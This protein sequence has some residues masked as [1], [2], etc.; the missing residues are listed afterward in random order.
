MNEIYQLKSHMK[1]LKGKEDV[2]IGVDPLDLLSKLSQGDRQGIVIN[3]VTA[4]KTNITIRGEA[5]SLS[6]IQLLQNK[7]KNAFDEVNISD[8]RASAQGRM[9]F[10]ITAREKRV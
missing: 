5:Q 10:T 9:M 8:S 4:D 3:E 2:F 6:D 7:L 1:E